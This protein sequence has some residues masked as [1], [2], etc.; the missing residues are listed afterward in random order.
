MCDIKNEAMS[1]N[2]YSAS[3]VTWMMSCTVQI[4]GYNQGSSMVVCISI[5]K[6]NKVM[7][8]TQNNWVW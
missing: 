4:N 3:S 5:S 2:V 6:I 7:K 8:E 1:F